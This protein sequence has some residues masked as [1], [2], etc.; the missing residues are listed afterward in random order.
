MLPLSN[1]WVF[2]FLFGAPSLVAPQPQAPGAAAALHPHVL[3][4]SWDS[5]A[6]DLCCTI[7]AEC[8]MFKRLRLYP[9]W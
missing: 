7:P 4:P 1:A 2:F 8:M 6:S 5:V 3:P 9:S